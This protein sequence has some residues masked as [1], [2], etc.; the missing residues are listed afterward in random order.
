[1]LDA[2]YKW[3]TPQTL[4]WAIVALPLSGALINGLYALLAAR[5]GQETSKT[6]TA[7]ISCGL[8]VLSFAATLILFVTLAGFPESH[9][10]VTPSLFIW[11]ATGGLSIDVALRFDEL[12]LIMCS[13]VTGVGSLIHIYSIGYMA[14]DK[15]GTRYF[16]YLNLFLTFMLILILGDNLLLLFVGWEGVGL[17]S[18]LLIG[19][20]FTD[21]EKAAAGKKA[22]IVNRIGDAGFL[23]GMFLLFATLATAVPESEATGNFL[24]FEVIRQY[25][26]Y[27]LP[28][29]TPICLCLFIGACGK[30]AQIPLYVWLPD[31]MAG[32]TPV[33]AL[34][35]AATMVTAGVYMVA[36]LSFLFVLSPFAMQTIA[37]VGAATALFAATIGLMQNDIKK[38]LAYSTVSQLGYMFLALGVGAFSAAI[39]HLM[40]HAFFKALLFL[41]A[42]SVIHAMHEEQDM[43]AYGGLKE[44]MPITCWTMV[45]A[46]FAISGIFPFA[47]FFSKDEILWQTYHSG[48]F[49]LWI[50]AVL[51]AG[52]TAFYMFRLLGMTFFGAPRD[53]AKFAKAHEAP[54]SMSMVLMVLGVLSLVGGFV[55]VPEAIGGAN[56]F[57]HWLERVFGTSVVHESAGGSQGVEIV[58]MV[59]CVLWAAIIGFVAWVTYSQ[60]S[61]W[62]SRS[63]QRFKGVY[64][65]VFNKYWID[66]VYD[67]LFVR[68]L[69][70]I[71]E[72]ILWKFFDA[73]MIDGGMVHGSG[74]VVL[75]WNRVLTR[76]QN[77]MVQQY[78]FFFLIGAVLL[79]WGVVF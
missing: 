27:L 69:V 36:R 50:I 74:R 70:W 48:H 75:G 39:F 45:I 72:K 66:E 4:A 71:S 28:V 68:P 46:T 2:I 11:V 33:S 3:V 51:A 61:D 6:A 37:V 15:G 9:R 55:G 60:G 29:A 63:A 73:G 43:R 32:P 44:K 67:F 77:G 62:P 24:D 52:M 34:I 8:P 5:F 53:P 20:W 49:G 26:A 25:S 42:G 57:H 59:S 17:C 38:V 19:F 7:L 12:S 35:H 16:A 14:H 31:A 30:S 18:Y 22:F 47:G 76:L 79:V 23:I 41:G 54:P 65:L 21:P 1:M 10:M 13:V 78:L 64:R 40:T 56:H 58:L